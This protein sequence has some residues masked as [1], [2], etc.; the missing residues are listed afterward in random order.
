MKNLNY[1]M[2]HFLYQIFKIIFKKHGEKTVN[3]SIRIYINKTENRIMLKIKTGYY[4]Q[5]LTPEIMKLL[6][7]TKSKIRKDKSGEN[8]P[9]LEITEIVLINCNFVNNSY[10]QNSR[11]LYRLVPNKLFCQLLDISPKNFMFLKTFTSEFSYV[12]VWFT[13]QN[14]NIK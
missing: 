3:P 7:S 13:D 2:D 9:C 4:L 11:V 8:V 14:V 10:Q 12:K 5:L 6:G 1:L